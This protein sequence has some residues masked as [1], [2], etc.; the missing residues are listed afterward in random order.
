MRRILMILVAALGAG[1]TDDHHPLGPGPAAEP[2]DATIAA[3]PLHLE[4]VADALSRVLPALED[5]ESHVLRAGLAAV[6][7]A[8][9]KGDLAALAAA[10]DAAQR[11]TDRM[12][13]EAAVG[14]AAELDVIRLALLQARIEARARS[15]MSHAGSVELHARTAD[16]LTHTSPIE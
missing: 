1:C 12:H 8:A 9:E 6:Q 13:G 14:A 3:L 7:Q 10:I 2:A 15:R 11:T 4:V 16:V 5:G